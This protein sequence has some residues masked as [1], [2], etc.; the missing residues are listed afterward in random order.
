RNDLV[1]SMPRTLADLSL[2]EFET[3]R[4]ALMSRAL[5]EAEL[6]GLSRA[7]LRFDWSLDMR[8]DRQTTE[9]N[10][11]CPAARSADLLAAIAQRFHARHEQLFN[12]RSPE[13]ITLVNVRLKVTSPGSS[14][15]FSGI[16]RAFL[17]RPSQPSG[18]R[19]RDA[20]FGPSHGTLRTRILTRAE[21][22]RKRV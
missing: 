1:S 5:R 11:E 4:E 22:H 12:Y 7:T 14:L 20:Y 3:S 10:V 17:G 8:Y 18:E 9:I 2:D 6:D 21:L 19:H 13:G 15:S 16:G